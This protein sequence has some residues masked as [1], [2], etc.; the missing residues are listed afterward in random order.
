MLLIYKKNK[1]N[2][3]ITKCVILNNIT[4]L[5]FK[6]VDSKSMTFTFKSLFM[7]KSE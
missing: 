3:G 2:F 4:T 1:E 7:L 5:T 6:G